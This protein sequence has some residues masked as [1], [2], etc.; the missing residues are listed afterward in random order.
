MA[1][2][3]NDQ[4][5]SSPEPQESIKAED[6]MREIASETYILT[7]ALT[8]YL[9]V[10]ARTCGVVHEL[11]TVEPFESDGFEADRVTVIGK[12]RPI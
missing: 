2:T 12:G 9:S 4:P 6:L 8:R 1:K 7:K 10:I 5:V 11:E 3:M